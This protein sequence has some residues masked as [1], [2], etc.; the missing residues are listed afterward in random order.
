MLRHYTFACLMKIEVVEEKRERWFCDSLIERESHDSKKLQYGAAINFEKN[1][2]V[3]PQ[4]FWEPLYTRS[5]D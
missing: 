5:N 3:F 1:S 2:K 4:N